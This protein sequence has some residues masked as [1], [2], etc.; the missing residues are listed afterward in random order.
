MIRLGKYQKSVENQYWECVNKII[1]IVKQNAIVSSSNKF[2]PSDF[3]SHNPCF[4]ELVLAPYDKIQKAFEYIEKNPNAMKQECF[5]PVNSTNRK[6][7]YE[8]LYTAYDKV[9]QR[10]VDKTKMNVMLVK[11]TGLTVCPYCNRD[12]INCRSDTLTGA[13]LD[14]FYP[15]SCYPVFSVCLYNL[16]PVCGNCNRIKG[17]DPKGFI[18]PFDEK[19][20]WNNEIRFSY[21]LIDA[22]K[23][24]IIINAQPLVKHNI[25]AMQIEGAYQ[26]HDLEVE[27]L[28]HKSKMYSRTQ[29]EEFSELFAKV[30]LT[31]QEIKQMV[32]GPIITEE[33]MKK[34]PLGR[35]LRDLERELDIYNL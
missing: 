15:R 8:T 22:D 29:C 21:K 5:L 19:I 27:E 10:I 24:K 1:P 35:M 13:Q 20:D 32:F 18:S 7:L 23:K 16:V 4:K 12:Y 34:K 11:N 6:P 2:L 14:H 25:D 3:F 31:E 28:L 30:G 9:F 33:D 26:I 17:K